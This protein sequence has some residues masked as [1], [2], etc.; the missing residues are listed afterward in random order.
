MQKESPQ[1]A[2]A[3]GR[4]M[5]LATLSGHIKQDDLFGQLKT[6]NSI[7]A[8]EGAAQVFAANLDRH[9]DD[10]LCI[11]GLKHILKSGDSS[12]QI[13]STVRHAFDPKRHGRYLDE[14]FAL[15]YIEAINPVGRHHDFHDFLD[16]IADLASRD[17]LAA[18]TVC[19]KLVS[20]LSDLGSPLQIWRTESLISAL[21]TILREADETDDV[22][23]IQRAVNLQDQF[24]RLDIRGI[25][26]YFEDAGRLSQFV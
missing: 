20:K 19:E 2:D 13:F 21:S 16:W 14:E 15:L 10:G 17:P 8:W 6:M 23:L 12:E 1:A 26:D 3:W 18:L 22:S 25:E 11:N 9:Q 4:I 7:Q 5:T 24:L